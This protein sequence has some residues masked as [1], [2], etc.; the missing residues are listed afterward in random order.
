MVDASLLDILCCPLC[1]GRF[2]P[3]DGQALRCAGC[4]TSFPIVHDVPRFVAT[5]ADETARRTQASFGY[6][7]THFNDWQQSGATNFNDYFHG[8]DLAALR[9]AVVLDAGCGMGRHARQIAPHAGR[10]VAVDFSRAIDEAIRNTAEVG[11]VCCLQA[12]LLAL[13]FRDAAFD[14]VYSLGVLHHIAD[15]P[16]ALEAIVTKLKP[17][18]RLL[19]YLYWRKHGWQGLLLKPATLARHV[20]TRLPPPLLRWACWLL[21]VA[22]FGLVVLPYRLLANAGVR[23]HARWPLFV[24]TKYPFGVLYNDQFDRFSAPIEQ[25]YDREEVAA[26][27]R[28][29]G[30]VD[31]QVRPCFGWLGSGVKPS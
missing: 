18:G 12:D 17:G 8:I 16:R 23:R 19:V 26:L 15:T 2:D 5:V 10:V 31:V 29:V 11:N 30:L 28:S 13:P 22:L 1:K 6:E 7:W 20:T 21:S 14:F 25:R 27:L 24:Y 3:A 9:R 4:G